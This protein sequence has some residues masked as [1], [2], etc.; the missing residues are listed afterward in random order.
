MNVQQEW[1]RCNMQKRAIAL[2]LFLMISI[3]GC[4][5]APDTNTAIQP[6]ESSDEPAQ[7]PAVAA[8]A[9]ENPTTA[10]DF[11]ES[12]LSQ[13][14]EHRKTIPDHADF[15]GQWQRTAVHSSLCA[16]ITIEES[17]DEGFDFSGEFYYY[18][19]TGDVA[20]KAF[21]VSENQAVYKQFEEND[22]D[23]EP[24]YIGFTIDDNGL[25]VITDGFVEGMG[26]NVAVNGDY[27]QEEPYY[28]NRN[29]V[30][31]NFSANDLDQLK[32]LLREETYN[33]LFLNETEIGNVTSEAA[34]LSD[35]TICRH[36][37]CTVPTMNTGYEML[38]TE[39]GRYYF[40][41]TSD[42]FA[43]N[44]ATYTDWRLP[45]YT[46]PE[47]EDQYAEDK[48]P[49]LLWEYEG[50]VDECA[51]YF[52]QE[53]FQNCD[54]DADGKQDRLS[55]AWSPE[56]QTAIYTIEFGNGKTLTVPPG[57]ET[58]FPHVQGG[59]LDGDGEKEILVTLSYDTSTDPSSFGDMWLF[60]KDASGKYKEVDLPLASGENGAKGF[61][62]EYDEPD[63]CIIRYSIK[64][65]GLSKS[66]EVG[67]DYVNNWWTTE[68]VT[69]MRS[70]YW[71]EMREGNNPAIRCYVEPLPRG[72]ASLGFNLSYRNGKY[73]IGYVE[74][75]APD[76]PF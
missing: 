52:W 57:W 10:L 16:D 12:N 48:S 36:I 43:T 22:I 4:G 35:G 26:M 59:D 38:I 60:D 71:A 23:N 5:K 7:A 53:D 29:V 37:E 27:V 31:E 44:D 34:V 14:Y 8:P 21:Y 13:I 9:A 19:H 20:G 28:T 41:H 69:N 17:D 6:S 18:S 63:G 49:L 50:Y 39:D 51:G 75:D 25:H 3:Y 74:I 61:T 24:A 47:E 72:G 40:F 76:G 46:L 11:T 62:I 70:V 68:K 33:N 65:A 1:E 73:E 15:S 64:E 45:D 54:Y 58:G 56:D 30:E 67:D 2:A 32:E 42:L 66:E 55:R